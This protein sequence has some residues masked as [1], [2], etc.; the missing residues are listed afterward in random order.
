MKFFTKIDFMGKVDFIFANVSLAIGALL[1]CI[2]LGYVWGVKKA[3]QEVYSGNPN[4]KL[5]PLWSFSMK[6]LSPVAILIIL[7]FIKTIAG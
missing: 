4:F 6:F 5:R 2:F 1:I 7:Y 3:A